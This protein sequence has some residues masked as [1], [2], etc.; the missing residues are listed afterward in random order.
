MNNVLPIDINIIFNYI[1]PQLIEEKT[2]VLE[3]AGLS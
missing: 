2:P 1:A 3:I